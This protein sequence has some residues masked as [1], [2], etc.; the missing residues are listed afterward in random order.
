MADW[1]AV[2]DFGNL[3]QYGTPEEIYHRPR[4]LFV[5]GFI[6]TPPINLI[7]GTFRTEGDK[8]FFKGDPFTIDLTHRRR[9]IEQGLRGD[10]IVLGARPKRVRVSPTP[11]EDGLTPGTVEVVEHLG[12]ETILHLRVNDLVVRASIPSAFDVKIGGRR[13]VQIDGSA[14]HVFDAETGRAVF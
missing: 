2:M 14:V 9:E 3:M 10:Q 1:I 13:W 6:G 11:S 8:A 7:R 5:A 12:S 4:N